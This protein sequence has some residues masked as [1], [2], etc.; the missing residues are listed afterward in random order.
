M[1][2]SISFESGQVVSIPVGRIQEL[3][4]FVKGEPLPVFALSL[5][6]GRVVSPATRRWDVLIEYSDLIDDVEEATGGVGEQLS[7][8]VVEVARGLAATTDGL[9]QDLLVNRLG[10][11]PPNQT[12]HGQF[13]SVAA[14]EHDDR[15]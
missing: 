2:G 11:S 4:A 3:T 15:S 13:E 6:V 12:E 9:R 14:D 1:F 5:P 10:P 7:Q 8:L